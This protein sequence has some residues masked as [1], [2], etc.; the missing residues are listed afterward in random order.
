MASPWVLL[1]WYKYSYKPN[2]LSILDLYKCIRESK[3]FI[4]DFRSS[5][6]HQYIPSTI[7]GYSFICDLEKPCSFIWSNNDISPP[8]SQKLN[9][10]II[11]LIQSPVSDI[12]S[13]NSSSFANPNSLIIRFDTEFIISWFSLIVRIKA[14]HIPNTSFGLDI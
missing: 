14:W 9:S 7:S 4:L 1:Y 12:V 6:D 5:F 13:L 3:A 10:G 2:N 11:H 8:K